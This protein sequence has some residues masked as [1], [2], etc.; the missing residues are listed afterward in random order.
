MSQQRYQVKGKIGQGG[1][2]A[3]FLADDT[4]LDREV[5]LKR[6]KPPEDGSAQAMAA[7][8]LREAKTLS[9][10]QHPNIVT[11]YDV[12]ADAEGPFV[13]LE[14]LKGET[15]DQVIER[16]AMTFE[17]FRQVVIQT[18]EGLIA[19]QAVG[20]VHRDLKPGNLMVVWLAS[21]KFQIKILD[22]G[23]AKFSQKAR[24]QTEDQGGGIFGSI[25]FMAPEQFER[26]PLDARTDM[27]SLGCIYYQILTTLHPFD[28]ET[29][30]QVM[31][32]HLQHHVTPLKQLRPDL[33]DWLC[34]WVMWLISREMDDRPPDAR[35]ALQFFMAEQHG[36]KHAPTVQPTQN[37]WQGAGRSGAS[38]H[39]PGPGTHPSTYGGTTQRVT[40]GGQAAAATARGSAPA[41]RPRKRR[42]KF[43]W[44]TLGAVLLAGGGFAAWYY[45]FRD[46]TLSPE[47][48]LASLEGQKAPQG[49]AATV[50][51]LGK[52]VRADQSAAKAVEVLKRLQGVGIGDALAGELERAN[53]DKA[54]ISLLDCLTEHPS[55]K[56]FQAIANLASS[57]NG[58]VNQAALRALPRH[59][60]PADVPALLK[61]AGERKEDAVK[62][63]EAVD[64]ALDQ[65][66]D[67]AARAKVLVAALKDA[68]PPV[69]SRLHEMLGRI[70]GDEAFRALKE[71]LSSKFPEVRKAALGAVALWPPD[72]KVAA[73]VLAAAQKSD[74][75]A[76]IDVYLRLLVRLPLTG[77]EKVAL[78]RKAQ[79]LTKGG[80]EDRFSRTLSGIADPAAAAYA[81]EIKDQRAADAITRLLGGTI[82]LAG[83]ET[84]LTTDKAVVDSPSGDASYSSAQRV[85]LGWK[86]PETR[87]GWD[88]QAKEAG[89]YQLQ[90]VHASNIRRL[91]TFR[92]VFG[93][94]S[95]PLA[96][97]N[98]E[99]TDRFDAADVGEFKLAKPGNY[100]LWIEPIS[101]ERGQVLMTLREVVVR[102]K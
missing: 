98:T 89:T 35:T 34:Y 43:L 18:L 8:L 82:S 38:R 41:Q 12:G 78:L 39:V 13:V 67:P 60:K 53:T 37:A 81:A 71:D 63:M 101:M 4:Q 56:G 1:L 5:A 9:A 15:L 80:A 92:V 19:A 27:Y 42:G 91:R 50:A 21:G 66:K 17:D 7:D 69:R 88:V 33:P 6:V 77:E 25:F 64:G 52:L 32:S 99:S 79:P 57:P 14:L 96:V 68:S 70:G 29:G 58:L 97:S 85:I 3:V 11:I 49:D 54:R 20:L 22:F 65:E 90:V 84:K 44:V 83:R 95:P 100:R 93:E 46:R 61:L 73:A 47:A 55:D 36:W 74:R 31:A 48:V 2:G 24:P 72:E 30:V 45:G 26:L 76:A 94:V 23:L 75:Q 102:K 59:A 16:G 51:Q 10:L 28:G 62:L 86:D 87:I 40:S